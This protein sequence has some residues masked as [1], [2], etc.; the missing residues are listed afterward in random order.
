MAGMDAMIPADC[1][2]YRGRTNGDSHHSSDQKCHKYQ[3][4]GKASHE[5]S[6][7]FTDTGILENEAQH[8]AA[9]ISRMIFPADD[10]DSVMIFVSSSLV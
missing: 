6:E 9:A 7:G 10:R 4:Q 5:I 8:T 2:G 3:R 1:H